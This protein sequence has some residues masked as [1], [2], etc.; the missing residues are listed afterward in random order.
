MEVRKLYFEKDG[1][2]TKKAFEDLEL[3][4]IDEIYRLEIAEHL[5]FC[6]ICTEKY[7]Q[8]LC[9]QEWENPGKSMA[10][11]I[12]RRVNRENRMI[13]LKRC[14]RVGFAACFTLLIWIGG[15]GKLEISTDNLPDFNTELRFGFS[16][17][18]SDSVNN[19]TQQVSENIEKFFDFDL[20]RS[21]EK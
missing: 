11:E 2:L 7:T 13:F 17:E 9:G 10:D 5:S 12:T 19:F 21:S 15:F 16:Q 14:A 4:C 8:F 1:H 18:I 6:D 3:G 20:E